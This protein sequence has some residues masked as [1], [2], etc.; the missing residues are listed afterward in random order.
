MQ[1]RNTVRKYSQE[2]AKPHQKPLKTA[3]NQKNSTRNQ[4]KPLKTASAAGAKRGVRSLPRRTVP[5]RQSSEAQPAK[6]RPGPCGQKW[7]NG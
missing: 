1:L 5:S 2:P 3:K 4:E 7:P 6:G